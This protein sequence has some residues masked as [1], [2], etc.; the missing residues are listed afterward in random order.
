MAPPG[1]CTG[2][3]VLAV[4]QI[5]QSLVAGGDLEGAAAWALVAQVVDDS[6]VELSLVLVD[7]SGDRLRWDGPGVRRNHQA[8]RLDR[9]VI[10]W[11]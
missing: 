10:G 2:G 7:L 9:I 4:G 5:E 1:V 6:L 8:T 11:C 3:H